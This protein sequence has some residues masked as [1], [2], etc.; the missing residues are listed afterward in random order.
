MQSHPAAPPT[1]TYTVFLTN[2]GA[3][4]QERYFREGEEDDRL[5]KQVWLFFNDA[6]ITLLSL[7]YARFS[8]NADD[9]VRSVMQVDLFATQAFRSLHIT[10]FRV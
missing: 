2:V 3:S 7:R 5:M 10:L 1:R 8:F 4:G 9:S 6:K